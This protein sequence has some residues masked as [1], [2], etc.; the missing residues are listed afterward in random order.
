MSWKIE[1]NLSSNPDLNLDDLFW[2]LFWSE[3]VS[4]KINKSNVWTE[5]KNIRKDNLKIKPTDSVTSKTDEY[6]QY[7]FEEIK[8]LH[9]SFKS[10]LKEIK[11]SLD[12]TKDDIQLEKNNIIWS[13]SLFVA[14]FTFI[15]TNITI[16]SKVDDVFTALI[17]MFW[18]IISIS[19]MLMIFFLFLTHKSWEPIIKN[20]LLLILWIL[21]SINLFSLWYFNNNKIPLSP[22]LEN[23]FE[24]FKKDNSELKTSLEEKVKSLETEN[25]TL[26]D[27]LE[28]QIS[29]EVKFQLLEQ[30]SKKT[31]N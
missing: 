11:L 15:S 29:K 20:P 1:W 31:S 18:M 30:Q 7:K 4:L 24:T 9:D 3:Q 17:L 19:I 22:S 8:K 12:K 2:N 23:K 26:K 28:Q 25:N 5:S 10:E 27:N 6:V 16:F 13:L 14:F 21:I